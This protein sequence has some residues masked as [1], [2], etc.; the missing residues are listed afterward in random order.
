[1]TNKPETPERA[2]FEPTL[3]SVGAHVIH[4]A[5]LFTVLGTVGSWITGDPPWGPD[6]VGM[7]VLMILAPTL[8]VSFGPERLRNAVNRVFR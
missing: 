1:M 6:L 3:R 7:L 8:L 5:I 2:M 4:A